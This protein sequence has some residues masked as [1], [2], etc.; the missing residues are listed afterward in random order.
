[1]HTAGIF[2]RDANRF[3]LSLDAVDV[4]P[5]CKAR[6][7]ILSADICLFRRPYEHDRAAIGALIYF[8]KIRAFAAN[9][10]QHE[11]G[12]P[13]VNGSILIWLFSQALR[14]LRLGVQSSHVKSLRPQRKTKKTRKQLKLRHYRVNEKLDTFA[15]AL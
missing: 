1:M 2:D 6:G 10:R 8:S 13:R 15:L 7:P 9:R 14:P 12:I 4:H 11:I 5:K 3:H